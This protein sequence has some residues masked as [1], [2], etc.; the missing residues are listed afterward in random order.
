MLVDV[1]SFWNKEVSVNVEALTES[2]PEI[3]VLKSK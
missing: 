1:K 3:S 2:L